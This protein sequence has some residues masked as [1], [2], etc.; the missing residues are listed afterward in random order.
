MAKVREKGKE[1]EVLVK[2]VSALFLSVCVFVIIV[3]VKVYPL[4]VVFE[5]QAPVPFG[6]WFRWIPV[7]LLRVLVIKN[8]FFWETEAEPQCYHAWWWVPFSS[9]ASCV[10]WQPRLVPVPLRQT[11]F[12]IL[13]SFLSRDGSWYALWRWQDYFFTKGL[14]CLFFKWNLCG[15]FLN[16]GCWFAIARNKKY[17]TCAE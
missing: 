3:L 17:H 6:V 11:S 5:Q 15:L 4:H 9:L 13:L 14:A 8:A 2:W 16:Y 12:W 7:L 10:C 1:K